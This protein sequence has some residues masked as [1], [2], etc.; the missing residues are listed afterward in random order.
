[1]SKRVGLLIWLAVTLSGVPAARAG[2]K[3]TFEKQN[4]K[5]TLYVEGDKMRAEETTPQ[6]ARVVIVDGKSKRLLFLDLENKAYT[7]MTEADMARLRTQMAEQRKQMQTQID[8]LPPDQRKQMEEMMQGHGGAEPLAQAPSELTFERLGQHRNV[9]GWACEMY[10]VLEGGKP[11][12]EDC[13]A[14][15]G[16][17][18]VARSDFAV[19]DQIES[20]FS[21]SLGV[22]DEHR[23]MGEL[24]KFPGF[25]VARTRIFPDGTKQPAEQLRSV[26]HERIPADKFSVPAGFKKREQL[27][28]K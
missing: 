10:R 19:V 7:E 20:S 5:Q 24:S 23:A 9:N 15:W 16:K 13:I 17:G 3:M 2:V 26:S 21:H 6:G 8:K 28:L 4:D 25:P 1:M 12:E 27:D 11:Q 18:L 22:K 14:P